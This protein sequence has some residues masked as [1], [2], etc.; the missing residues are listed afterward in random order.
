M[1][2]IASRKAAGELGD[3]SG[4]PIRDLRRYRDYLI[5]LARNQLP[6]RLLA[7]L[8]PSDV[9]QQTML[10]AHRDRAQFRGTTS[11]EVAGWLRGILAHKLA[12][13]AR[14]FE[15]DKRDIGREVSLQKSIE[16]SSVRLEGW[17]RDG[18]LSPPEQA[19]RNEQLLSLASALAEL[20]ND[21][22]EA[23]EMRY[24]KSMPVKDIAMELGRT[25]SAVGGL[26]HRG[27]VH[28]QARMAKTC[29]A[30]VSDV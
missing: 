8:D 13:A 20:P 12:N 29:I 4:D 27:L 26:L 9:V 28:L 18:R 16:E 10:E 21:Q 1:R 23:I 3:D 24:L 22:R 6:A 14:D 15:R 11:A 25:S 2:P 19:D 30:G 17:L 7:K 5:L